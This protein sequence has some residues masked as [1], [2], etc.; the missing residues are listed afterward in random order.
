MK[1]TTLAVGAA[2]AMTV[3]AGGSA[4][5]QNE[6]RPDRGLRAD[7]DGDGRISRAEFVD[8]R[9]TRLTAVDANRDGSVSVEERRSGVET[10]RNQRVSARFE[11]LDQDSDGA[12]SREELTADSEMRGERAGRGGR[13]AMGGR[14][15]HRGGLGGGE[16]GPRAEAAGPFSIAEVQT[17]M[18][19][20]FDR[21]DA[22]K[23]GFV[24]LDERRAI[25]DGMR[26][27][28]RA[29]QTIGQP[30]P[31]ATASE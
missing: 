16:R 27:Q 5:A 3:L 15:G 25:R 11:R 6:A 30:S 17:R 1:K 19:T 29:R 21:I 9:I 13:H 31:S 7:A 12:V 28:R 10:R 26:E 22:D 20:Q 4:L 8:R 24:T 14:G 2:I 23:D 18:A